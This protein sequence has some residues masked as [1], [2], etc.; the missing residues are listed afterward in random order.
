MKFKELELSEPVLKAINDLEYNEATYI[1]ASCIPIILNDGDVLGQSQ[2]G[3]GKTAAF[4][5]PIIDRIQKNEGKRKVQTL[6]LSP[7]RELALQVSDELRKF[8]KYKENIKI[9]TIYGGT[10]FQDQ[11]SN[12]KKGC[13]IIVGCPGRILDHLDKK[14]LKLDGCKTLVLDEADEM[15]NMGFREDIEKIISY[16]PEERQ[17]LLFSAT[18][19]QA[20]KDIAKNYQKNPVFIK[21]PETKLTNSKINQIAYECAQK[22]KQKALIQM[23]ELRRPKLAMIFC[24]TKKMVDDL[25]AEL[26]SKGYPASA[27]HGDM[28]QDARSHVMERF[29]KGQVT[30]LVCTDV[31]ARGIDVS[32]MDVVF[33][34]DIPQENEYYV[35]RIGRTG[36]AGN[37]GVAITLFTPRQKAELK[38]L[39]KLTKSIIDIRKL[40]TKEMIDDI[41]IYQIQDELLNSLD[42]KTNKELNNMVIDLIENQGIDERALLLSIIN[43]LYGSSMLEAIDAPIQSNSLK[44]N[45]KRKSNIIINLGSKDGITPAHIVSGISEATGLSSKDIG[46]IIIEDRITTVAIPDDIK[47]E[48]VKLVNQTKI[49]NKKVKAEV[50]RQKGRERNFDSKRKDKKPS[51]YKDKKSDGRRRK[52]KRD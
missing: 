10:S 46:K 34:Y 6:I 8:S 15:L 13:E 31:A 25:T 50:S 45:S 22:D 3:T 12:I 17:T 26:V 39:E 7:T 38:A 18:M 40:P 47:E 16:I 33:N 24:N 42:K 14:I 20:I 52:S 30:Y 29:K 19:P 11:I 35:H 51:R 32:N 1:Q 23:I 44:S 48:I 27:I 37:E 2:T 21:N 5:L 43:N 41:R 49:K 4:G 9:I 28:K 36:R